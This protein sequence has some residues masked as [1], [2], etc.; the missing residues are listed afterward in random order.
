MPDRSLNRYPFYCPRFWHGMRPKTWW[1][2]LKMGRFE[3]SPSR[4]PMAAIITSA[5]IFNTAFTGIQSLLFRRKLREAELHGPPVFII[6]HWRSGTTLLH[7]LMVRDE[8]FSSPTTYQCFAPSHFLL[9]QWFFRTFLGWLLPGKRPM[10]NMDAGWDRPQEDEFAMVNLGQPSP[11]RRIAF[12]NQGSV[13]MEY[14]DLDDISEEDRNAWLQT[15]K[16]FL[17]RVSIATTRPLVIK[18]PTHTGRVGYLAK[19][20]PHA[21][22]I[23]I[24]RD[25]RA[26]FPSTCRLWRS[27]DAVQGL[28]AVSSDEGHDANATESIEE[29][30]LKCL[31]Q[32][33]SAFHANRDQIA[34]HHIIDIR[35]E[36]LIADPITTLQ[37]IYETLRLADFE[38]V[39]EQIQTWAD[40][41][42]KDYQANSHKLSNEQETVLLDR[43]REYFERYGY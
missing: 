20:F 36:D 34:P 27:L 24:T 21:K 39:R 32:M 40:T 25:P 11:Y 30:V 16:D 28:Q 17:H 7:E 3:V 41:E 42:H 35:Y 9:T 38:T 22:F 23:H 4:L 37:S 19:A 26:L 1:N 15:L 10:D 18:S 2:L 13:D 6:G 12:P 5:T 33:Y 43:W 14:L 31:D 29:Y 8:R